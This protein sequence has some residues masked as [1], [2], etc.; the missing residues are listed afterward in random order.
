MT[1]KTCTYLSIAFLCALGSP[2]IAGTPAED[3]AKALREGNNRFVSGKP[4]RRNTGMDR[5]KDTGANGQKPIVTILGCSDAR[6]PLEQIFDLGIGDIFTVRVAGNV[7]DT[8]EIGSA[9]YGTGHLNTPLMLVLG[10]TKC[11]AVTAVVTGAQVHG[12]IPGLIDNIIPAVE[13]AKKKNPGVTGK[14]LVPF[15]VEENV[16]QSIRGTLTRSETIRSLVKEGKLQVVGG[17]YDIDTGKVAWL[18]Q[19][20]EQSALLS[21]PVVASAERSTGHG[22]GTTSAQSENTNSASASDSKVAST[23]TFAAADTKPDQRAPY[24]AKAG[25]AVVEEDVKEPLPTSSLFT[26][27]FGVTAGLSLLL[28]MAVAFALSRTTNA[29]GSAAR[30]M[31]IGTKLAGGFGL[32]VTG[33]LLLAT[34]SSRSGNTVS[35]SAAANE[36]LS[37]QYSLVASIE[38]EM[39]AIRLQA[40]RFLLTNNEAEL[41]K[42]SDS[43][44]AF[45]SRLDSAK[46][47]IKN[48]ERV[49]LVEKIGSDIDQYAQT[50]SEVVRGIDER[51]AII[52]QQMGPA[53]GRASEL[54]SEISKT[55]HADRDAKVGIAAATTNNRLQLARLAFFKFVRTGDVKFE[56]EAKAHATAV[57]EELAVLETNVN[58]P[59]RKAWLKE[60][61]QAITLWVTK[62]DHAADL[63]EKRNTLVKNG[64]DKIGPQIAAAT[65]ELQTSLSRTKTELAAKAETATRTAATIVTIVAFLSAGLGVCMS[66]IIIRG[67]TGPLSRVVTALK[68]VAAGDLTAPLMKMTSRDEVGILGHATDAMSEMLKKMVGE[69]KGT[70]SQVAAAATEVAASAEELSQTVRSQEQAATQ[71][72][73][74]VTELSASITEVANKSSD[75]ATSARDSMKQAAAGGDLVQQTV[76]QLGQINDRF[77]EVGSVV[78]TLEQQGQEVGRIVQVIQDIADQTNLLALNA[79]IEAARAGEH[80]R[81]FA[82]VAD[83]VRKLAERTT[84]A[85]GEVAST[86]GGMQQGT[87]KAAEAMKVG[88]QTVEEGARMGG[89]AGDAVGVIVKAQK[90]AEQMAASIAAATQQQASATEEISRTI[91]Q[92]TAANSQSAGAASQASQAA[93]SLSQQAEVLKRS[94]ERYKV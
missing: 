34:I 41:A 91:E 37:K 20:P 21:A 67:V 27:I 76:T 81:G 24:G 16:F 38:S 47:T 62:M 84:Q 86:I 5:V 6:V 3:A 23:G 48:P 73:S 15:A 49:K 18:G 94:M 90:A 56:T 85:T 52:D 42:Y 78:S 45:A 19:H 87:V 30:A 11:G 13:S 28:T 53:A 68:S 54:L 25:K 14:D 35:D 88:R 69:I 26:T 39:L 1:K 8:D 40:N 55:G 12:S 46:Q 36:H 58:N 93:N 70:S 10:H 59:T 80:G 82:V 50:F 17:I 60:A 89:Q 32:M 63:Q 83:E 7:S 71:V 4:E 64:L 57:K 66:M 79:A 33:M 61:T 72:A 51:N 31:T 74:A 44:A 75:S 2:A 9:E 77:S 92:M 29:D 22:S 65:N 43:A